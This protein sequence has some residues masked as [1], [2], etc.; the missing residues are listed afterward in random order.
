MN[1]KPVSDGAIWGA[2][3]RVMG[4]VPWGWFFGWAGLAAQLIGL[5][6]I[7]LIE[8]RDWRKSRRG[9]E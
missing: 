1:M 6:G 7:V 5:T 9:A 4:I 3:F 8:V 2:I